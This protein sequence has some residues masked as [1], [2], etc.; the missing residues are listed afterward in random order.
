MTD[1]PD[2]PYEPHPEQVA[3]IPS[4]SG[5]EINGLGETEKRRPTV[6]YWDNPETLPHGQLMMWYVRRNYQGDRLKTRRRAEEIEAGILEPVAD[7]AIEDSAANWTA[8]VKQEALDLG[9]TQVGI[10]AIDPNW[11]FDRYEVG[12]K[13]VIVLAQP[14]EYDLIATSPS[15]PALNEVLEKYNDIYIKSRQIADW[16]RQQGWQADPYGGVANPDRLTIIPGAVESGIGQLGKHGSTIS[17]VSG[18]CF[19][20]AFVLSDLP[21]VPDAPQDIGVDE[22]CTS[23]KLC[24]EACPPEAIKPVKQLVRG[25]E[26]WYVDF[27]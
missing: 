7:T 3:L 10:S 18:P 11:V 16:I 25:T 27:D 2:R 21:L 12:F 1:A 14:M 8:K 6:I 23:C 15:G 26:K 5:N 17:P 4:V 22:F 24:Q 19:R 20:L 9:A 13:W